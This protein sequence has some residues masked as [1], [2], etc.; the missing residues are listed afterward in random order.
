MP[1]APLAPLAL[2][3]LLAPTALTGCGGGAAAAAPAARPAGPGA[4]TSAG[5]VASVDDSRAALDALAARGP[6]DAPLMRER[7]RVERA[8]GST[9]L[10]RAERDLC[11]RA[12]FSASRD[13]RAW[14]ADESGVMRGDVTTAATGTV[15]P[16][17]PA[18]AK[19]GEVLRLVIEDAP[20][21]RAVIF[22]A[23]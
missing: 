7:L 4:G 14:F 17:G 3:V 23:P 13:V 10:P 18:C 12:I 8:G 9:A 21:V 5:T 22:A 19:K 6:T 15:P 2:L 16:R 20:P 11:V 1:I